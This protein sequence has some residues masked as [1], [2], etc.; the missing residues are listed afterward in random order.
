M[1]RRRPLF[2]EIHSRRNQEIP[3]GIMSH[4][5][6]ASQ[7]H[8]YD[9]DE[10]RYMKKILCTF[11]SAGKKLTFE[12]MYTQ[13]KAVCNILGIDGTT[14]IMMTAFRTLL[15][16]HKP[17]SHDTRP[18]TDVSILFNGQQGFQ[19]PLSIIITA[20]NPIFNTV[21]LVT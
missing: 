17:F 21:S 13:V 8:I 20:T 9:Y 15:D 2:S 6:F 1:L 18:T 19:A 14:R 3:V 7:S 4:M 16:Q 11:E 10:R 12:E 5:A